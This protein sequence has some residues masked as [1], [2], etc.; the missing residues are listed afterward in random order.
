MK[1]YALSLGTLI[2][3]SGSL[4]LSQ[5]TTFASTMSTTTNTTSVT[6]LSC[7]VSALDIRENTLLTGWNTYSSGISA[8]YSAR[9]LSLDSAWQITDRTERK[10]AIKAAW[11][12]FESTRKS[13]AAT[14]KT[15]N[16]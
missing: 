6:T 8:A 10:S 2:I 4:F 14:W 12:T 7:M 9:I 15:T 11:S 3:V 5:A 16:K 1:K 13:E